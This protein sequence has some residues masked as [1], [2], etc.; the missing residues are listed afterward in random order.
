MRCET[1][2][3]PTWELGPG[4]LQNASALKRSH[5]FKEED[6]TKILKRIVKRNRFCSTSFHVIDTFLE[7]IHVPGAIN[8]L[9]CLHTEEYQL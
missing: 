5:L 1:C 9:Y 8:F 7:K 4:T 3:T 6:F 2:V